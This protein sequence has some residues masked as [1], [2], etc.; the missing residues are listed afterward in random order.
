M[1]ARV[2]RDLRGVAI[3]HA[4]LGNVEA[5]LDWLDKSLA[6]RG[7]QFCYIGVDPAFDPLRSHSRF[8]A[9]LRQAGLPA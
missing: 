4:G 2:R 3:A 1:S 9:L 8:K 5:S 6:E 7:A